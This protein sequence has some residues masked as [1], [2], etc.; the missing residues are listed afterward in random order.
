E[1]HP[2]LGQ[3]AAAPG[4]A[5]VPAAA[6]RHARCPA[7]RRGTGARR[8]RAPPARRRPPAQ[9]A[10]E[11]DEALGTRETLRQEVRMSERKR[12]LELLDR[13]FKAQAWHGPALMETL[14]GVDANMA[15][16]RIVKGGHTIWELVDHLANWNTIVAARIAGAKPKQ[17]DPNM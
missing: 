10:R 16:K 14:A 3:E 1:A 8:R 12:T 6:A 15:A 5:A 13:A 7:H 9:A 17:I 11:P 4:R 2:A